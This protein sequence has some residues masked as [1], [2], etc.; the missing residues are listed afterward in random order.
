MGTACKC[1]D[2]DPKAP[3]AAKAA[4]SACELEKYKGDG[5]CDDGNN[6]AGCEYDGGDCCEKSLGKA[7]S[8]HF[9]TACKCLDPDP[10]APEAAKAAESACELEQYKGDGNCDDGNNNAGC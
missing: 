4:E 7:I 5:N 2:P 6:N 10:K 1:L 8:K 9:C 3:E